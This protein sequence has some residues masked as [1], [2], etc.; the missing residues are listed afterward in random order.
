[1]YRRIRGEKGKEEWLKKVIGL[2]TTLVSEES[3]LKVK[4]IV[5]N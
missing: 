5:I 2:D 3:I 4:S 1:L